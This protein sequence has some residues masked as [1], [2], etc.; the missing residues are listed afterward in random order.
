VKARA[1]AFQRAA[2]VDV[3]R[4]R[5]RLAELWDERGP[6]DSPLEELYRLKA[7]AM[8]EH[9]AA[10]VAE[11][12]QDGSMAVR[13]VRLTYGR[14][15]FTPD[16]VVTLADGTEQQRRIRTGRISSSEKNHPIY[17]LYAR[18][19]DPARSPSAEPRQLQAVSLTTGTTQGMPLTDKVIAGRLDR[20]N[21]AIAGL[22][23][24]AYPPRPEEARHCCTCPHYFTCPAGG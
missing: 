7:E 17:A 5:V 19:R 20:Y 12:A 24:E 9:L 3:A 14:V 15:T 13:E 23:V 2:A 21:D 1:Y 11:R 4:A 8:I 10:L 16:D 6:K 22:L 18:G